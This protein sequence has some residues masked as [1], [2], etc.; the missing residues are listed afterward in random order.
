MKIAI[1]QPNFMPW[2]GY[3]YKM[4]QADVFVIL[5]NV[6]Y[7]KNGY[8]NRVKIKTAQGAIWLTLP[9]QRQ[10]PQTIQQIKLANFSQ[11]KEKILKTIA[12]NYTK[13]P[14]FDDLFPQLKKIFS[15]DWQYLADLNLRLLKLLKRKLGIKTKLVTA[16][17][18]KING[19]ADDLLIELCQA[20]S[21]KT[22][23][24]GSGG[25]KYQ[26]ENKFKKSGLKL[27]YC[28]FNHPTYQ[29]LY[30]PFIPGLSVIDLL[31]NHGPASAE[32]L[33]KKN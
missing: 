20:L 4:A 28:D 27:E 19:K 1:H 30:P 33:L 18:F 12:Q 3:F 10:F 13:A 14:Y 22:Y 26:D 7:E 25:S 21:A 5:N 31:F 2:L 9:I 15:R 17:Q 32:I 6:Q 11:I 24:S 8:T 23:I 16:S 29:Q